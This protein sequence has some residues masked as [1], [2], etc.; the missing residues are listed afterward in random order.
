MLGFRC[1]AWRFVF[2]FR[3]R[4][5]GRRELVLNGRNEIAVSDS[6][7]S[8][9]A[10]VTAGWAL[11]ALAPPDSPA[12]GSSE[13]RADNN[14][15][16]WNDSRLSYPWRMRTLGGRL[17]R[18]WAIARSHGRVSRF[19]VCT[20]S[21]CASPRPPKIGQSIHIRHARAGPSTVTPSARVALVQKRT[22]DEKRGPAN[23][24]QRPMPSPSVADDPS[25]EGTRPR[26]STGTGTD[27]DGCALITRRCHS[28]REGENA[29]SRP[30]ARRS[31][32]DADAFAG[33]CTVIVSSVR[34]GAVTASTVSSLSAQRSGLATC[35]GI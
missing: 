35:G 18:R 5:R 21:S 9:D 25:G 32:P 31:H 30:A 19:I 8:T 20:R 33:P 10:P 6:N 16:E 26:A 27:T 29:S 23:A 12:Q 17:E 2:R 3:V 14:Q 28:G 1:T 24:P 4:V 7:L 34:P 13:R 15:I 11:L 22:D